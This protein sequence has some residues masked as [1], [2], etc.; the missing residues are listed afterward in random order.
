MTKIECEQIGH[1]ERRFFDQVVYFGNKEEIEEGQFAAAHTQYAM[2]DLF[3]FRDTRVGFYYN[4]DLECQREIG[5]HDL[6]TRILIVF[7]GH[8]VK[9]G[10]IDIKKDDKTGE[11]VPVD[12]DEIMFTLGSNM[13]KGTPQWSERA[14]FA[15]FKLRHH[16]IVYYM[17]KG[18]TPESIRNDWRSYLMAKIAKKMQDYYSKFSIIPIVQSWDHDDRKDAT[19]MKPLRD[20]LQIQSEGELPHIF[21]YHSTSDTTIKYPDP[22]VNLE[23]FSPE[24]ITS[25]GEYALMRANMR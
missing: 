13:P 21:A 8:D 7:H 4:D 22:I 12:K 24:L 10:V 20:L 16:A 23:D 11:W 25:W 9:P 2:E 18:E 15:L 6:E 14:G 19:T 17:P 3:M 1:P 5:Q